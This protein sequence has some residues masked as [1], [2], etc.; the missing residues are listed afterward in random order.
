MDEG[1]RVRV[2]NVGNDREGSS[3]EPLRLSFFPI[4]H[5]QIGEKIESGVRF[6]WESGR[7]I[8]GSLGRVVH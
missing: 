1:E 8:Y 5:E 3:G 2:C 7:C 4:F 6:W